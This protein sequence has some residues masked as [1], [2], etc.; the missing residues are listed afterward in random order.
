M[1]NTV[2]YSYSAHCYPDI[3]EEMIALIEGT[4]GV[5]AA[6]GPVMGSFVYQIVGYSWTWYIFGIL[7]LPTVFLS[8]QLKSEQEIHEMREKASKVDADACDGG[9]A[10]SLEEAKAQE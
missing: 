2:S 10:E 4:T 8:L 1:I 6:F 5:G 3:L 7:I 9:W